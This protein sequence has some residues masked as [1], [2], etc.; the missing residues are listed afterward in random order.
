MS[1]QVM[2]EISG[3]V[4]VITVDNPPLNLLSVEVT[5]GLINAI[6]EFETAGLRALVVRAAGKNFSGG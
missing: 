1:S 4:G 3:N 2:R 6:D 5:D